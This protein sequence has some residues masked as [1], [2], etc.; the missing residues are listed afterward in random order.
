MKLFPGATWRPLGPQ[1]QGDMTA[2]DVICLHTMVGSL[3]GTDGY[4]LSSGYGGT[5]SHFGV[6]NEADKR[7]LQWQDLAHT[8]DANYEGNPRVLSIECSDKGSGFPA[9]TGVDVPVF[10]AWQLETLARLIAWLADP[11]T[12]SECPTGWK[13]R[14]EGI[15]LALVRSSA[16][17]ERGIG[18]HRQGVDPYRAAGTE[19]WS[20]VTG[21]AC[22][23]L[24]TTE[25]LTSRGWT[26]LGSVKEEDLVAS[27]SLDHAGEVTFSRALR[28]AP[29]EEEVIRVGPFESTK[30]H[31]W[32]TLDAESGAWKKVAASDIQQGAQAPAAGRW[33]GAG[34]GAGGLGL[35]ES[36][37]RLIARLMSGA[38]AVPASQLL[39]MTP[40]EA[41]IFLDELFP[42]GVQFWP[43]PP[44]NHPVPVES[45]NA[46][47]ALGAV[48]SW[49]LLLHTTLSGR[50]LLVRSDQTVKLAPDEAQE[51]D[52]R[53]TLVTCLT[54]VDGTL[55]IR[56]GGHVAV[57]GNCPGDRRIDQIPGII[58]RAV[59]MS[60]SGAWDEQI[61]RPADFGTADNKSTTAKAADVLRWSFTNSKRALTEVRELRKQLDELI[62]RLPPAS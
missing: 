53:T 6:G 51:T 54:T 27:V 41:D 5:E 16:K 34:A 49:P 19:R 24:D 26:P 32:V 2:H 47:Q 45:L 22:F 44:L 4:F 62:K 29:F 28:I 15:P 23:P 31:E 11:R 39:K 38:G 10:D 3:T 17:T 57:T 52:T 12:H 14:S 1:T 25:V 7:V 36:E 48:H 42:E 21:K 43:R 60:S 40:A 18:Y 50:K 35:R 33:A 37:I 13:C 46:V 56:Q 59:S 30:D 8:A 9:W 58:K 61:R 55:I 20:T